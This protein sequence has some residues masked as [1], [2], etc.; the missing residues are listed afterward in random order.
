MCGSGTIPIEAGL[1]A[2]G[3]APGL[4]RKSFGLLTWGGHDRALWRRLVDEAIEADGRD[5]PSTLAIFVASRA[6]YQ[7]GDVQARSWMVSGKR[8]S[9]H[10]A[11]RRGSPSRA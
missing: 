2:A 8:E 7:M 3:V 4:L 9:S 1:I 5:D 11:G 6:S 10:K